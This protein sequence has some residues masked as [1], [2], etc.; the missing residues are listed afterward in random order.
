[1]RMTGRWSNEAGAHAGF[2]S[3]ELNDY[4]SV[5]SAV[6]RTSRTFT[7]ATCIGGAK[8]GSTH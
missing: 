7:I 8:R 1:M 3:R 4:C 2:T 6:L 5:S